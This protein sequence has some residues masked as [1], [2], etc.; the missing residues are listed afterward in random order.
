MKIKIHKKTL[1]CFFCLFIQ[2]LLHPLG[3]EKNKQEDL[4]KALV[5]LEKKQIDYPHDPV[6]NYN[7]GVALY[8]AGKFDQ[9]KN[10]FDRAIK[11]GEHTT[12]LLKKAYFNGGNSCYKHA[13][14][15]LG[16]GWE[17]KDVDQKLLDEAIGKVKSSIQSFE[18]FLVFEKENE[19]GKKNLQA[20]EALLK[21]LEE[22][23]KQEQQKQDQKEKDKDKQN[24][25]KQDKEQKDK[26]DKQQDKEQKSDKQQQDKQQDKQQDSKQEGD[27]QQQ[28]GQQDK[29]QDQKQEGD[30]DQ[31]EQEK[32]EQEQKSAE[33]QEKKEQ[34][35]E[36]K[37]AEQ[38]KAQQEAQQK[39]AG[40]KKDQF[41]SVNQEDHPGNRDE[42][43]ERRGMRTILDNLQEDEAKLQKELI[44][45]KIRGQQS[46]EQTGQKPW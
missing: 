3:G 26:Q 28:D 32:K 22:K 27:K 37:Q 31:Q 45:K 40:E 44:Q 33:K 41:S 1:L 8:K 16:S 36:Q 38:Q 43:F 6:V 35:D 9:A 39:N 24:K 5:A 18:K 10:N 19:R 4:E 11:Y 20:S 7:F 25:Q 17:K 13:L 46:E 14:A 23:K 42:S 29:Q 12:E 2:S 34:K 21:K 30:R 15:K